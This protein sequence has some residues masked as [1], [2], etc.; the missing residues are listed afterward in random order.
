MQEH[1]L[2][3]NIYNYLLFNRVKYEN[4][5]HK[6]NSFFLFFSLLYIKLL[7]KLKKLIELKRIKLLVTISIYY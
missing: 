1:E 6:T 5:K 4:K 3:I 7:I 2:L